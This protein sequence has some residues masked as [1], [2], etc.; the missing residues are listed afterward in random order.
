M[1]IKRAVHSR[2]KKAAVFKQAKGFRGGRGRLWRTVKNAVDRANT[3]AYRDRKVKKRDFRRLWI[4]R[5]N[6]AVREAGISY[7]Q[8]IH[9]LKKAEIDLD[10]R[11]MAYLAM[12]EPE[13]FT[14]II[15]E[16]KGLIVDPKAAAVAA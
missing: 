7:S 12:N 9:A 3:Y 1:R 11:T 8:F 15:N 16:V 13:T 5:I 6:A 2:K 4:M 10:R 14:A